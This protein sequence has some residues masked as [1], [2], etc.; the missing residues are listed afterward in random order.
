M[1]NRK[2]E[3]IKRLEKGCIP[4]SCFVCKE[5]DK[6][7]NYTDCPYNKIKQIARERKLTVDDIPAELVK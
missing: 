3:L 5:G 4:A 2:L 1:N 6:Y 7:E